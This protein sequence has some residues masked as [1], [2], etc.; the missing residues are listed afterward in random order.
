MTVAYGMQP[1]GGVALGSLDLLEPQGQFEI[2]EITA[3]A[4][5]GMGEAE[6]QL[7]QSLPHASFDVVIMNPPFTRVTSHEGATS[8]VPNPMFAAFSSSAKAQRLMAEE[9]K[10][11]TRGPAPTGTRAKPRSSSFW[12]TAN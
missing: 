1:D 10:H 12:L 2:L 5:E 6:R 9:T 4:A 7:W 8:A 11:L 3:R